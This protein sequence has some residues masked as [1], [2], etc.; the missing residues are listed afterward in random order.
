MKQNMIRLA[1]G[2]T[3]ISAF[4]ASAQDLKEYKSKPGGDTK[5][6]VEGTSNIHDWWVESKMIAGSMKLDAAALAKGTPGKLQAELKVIIRVSSMHSSSGSSMDDVMYKQ[7]EVENDPDFQRIVY[8]LKE[9]ELKKAPGD[10]LA[11]GDLIIHGV[12]NTISMPVTLEKDSEDLI[13]SS[14]ID[15]K[16]TDFKIAPPCLNL[17]AMKIE[18]G[19]KIKV[20]IRWRVT[21]MVK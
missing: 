2:I 6:R 10:L 11:K 12:T 14:T 9:L 5:A 15:M 1:L 4:A 17:L 18:T 13:F 7:M 20:I 8:I 21:P 3:L 19:D 16:M